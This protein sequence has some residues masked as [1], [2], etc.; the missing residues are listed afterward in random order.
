MYDID[1]G[2]LTMAEAKRDFK[3]GHLDTWRIDRMKLQE[4]LGKPYF[5]WFVRVGRE[6]RPLDL[7]GDARTR[8]PREFVSVEAAIGAL[9]QI[10]FEV[11]LC[12]SI[13]PRTL[14]EEWNR[15]AVDGGLG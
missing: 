8:M 14:E 10:G 3:R 15:P 9:E 1:R 12:I 13:K 6:G 2:D 4:G 5:R 7:L 11:G